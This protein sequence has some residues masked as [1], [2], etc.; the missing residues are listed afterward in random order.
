MPGAAATDSASVTPATLYSNLGILTMDGAG[1]FSITYWEN[2]GGTIKRDGTNSTP[3][4]GTYSI[5][6][7]TCAVGLS[8]TGTKGP[9]FNTIAAAGGLGAVHSFAVGADAHG[10]NVRERRTGRE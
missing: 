5:N 4:Y 7:A 9:A 2:Q 1:N 3:F 6:P 8:Y 10:R